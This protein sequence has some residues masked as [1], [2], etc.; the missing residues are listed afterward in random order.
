MSNLEELSKLADTA[1]TKIKNLETIIDGLKSEQENFVNYKKTLIAQLKHLKKTMRK[2]QKEADTVVAE[3][4]ALK[5]ENAELKEANA[6][7]NY[8]V[9]HLVRNTFTTEDVHPEAMVI[10]ED[11]QFVKK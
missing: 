9:N 6:K 10:P 5:K 11:F 8:R 4:E 2:D 7:L 3:Y 1:E